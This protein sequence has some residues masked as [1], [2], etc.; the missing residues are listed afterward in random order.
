VTTW[1]CPKHGIVE[2]PPLAD[3]SMHAIAGRPDRVC[4]MKCERVEAVPCA[5]V[6]LLLALTER[7]L[8]LALAQRDQAVHVA[9]APMVRQTIANVEALW[10]VPCGDPNCQNPDCQ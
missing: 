10:G 6:E 4:L 1:R 8:D 7:A 3:G 9:L 2:L 5:R